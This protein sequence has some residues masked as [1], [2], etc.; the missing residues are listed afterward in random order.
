VEETHREEWI[1]RRSNAIGAKKV[2]FPPP[3]PTP[4]PGP[5]GCLQPKAPISAQAVAE[6]L[7]LQQQV[8]AHSIQAQAPQQ[9]QQHALQQ[10]HLP[11]PQEQVW[12]GT[13]QTQVAPLEPQQAPMQMA[14]FTPAATAPRRPWPLLCTT[15]HTPLRVGGTTPRMQQFMGEHCAADAVQKLRERGFGSSMLT[16]HYYEGY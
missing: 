14:Q 12:G 3:P 1:R 6:Y 11:L 10:P 15:P 2:Q 5:V 4:L 16:S 7:E 13:S 8:C 9:P